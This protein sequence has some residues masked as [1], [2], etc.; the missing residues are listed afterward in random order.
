[1]A[2]CCLTLAALA[3]TI[4]TAC[5]FSWS[6]GLAAL[7]TRPVAVLCLPMARLSNSIRITLETVAKLI[8]LRLHSAA[9]IPLEHLHLV[10]VS[11][12]CFA[13]VRLGGLASTM[14]LGA[15]C[16]SLADVRDL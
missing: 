5:R 15:G 14:C 7:A 10:F 16:E 1:M 6:R 2:A 8:E 3:N 12:V 11:R 13:A 9:R 4:T